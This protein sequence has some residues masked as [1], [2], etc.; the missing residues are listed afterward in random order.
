MLNED[1]H[2]FWEVDSVIFDGS[3]KNSGVSYKRT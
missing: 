1:Y 2:C 3:N